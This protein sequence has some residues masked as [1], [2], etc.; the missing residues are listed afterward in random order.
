MTPPHH[1]PEIL[2]LHRGAV[3]AMPSARSGLLR[4]TPEVVVALREPA[5]IARRAS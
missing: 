1:Q 3:R 5:A 4:T 2:A